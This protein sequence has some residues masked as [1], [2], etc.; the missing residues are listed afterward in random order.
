[1]ENS[2]AIYDE[3][4]DKKYPGVKKAK[5]RKGRVIILNNR[6]IEILDISADT[7]ENGGATYEVRDTKPV[8]DRDGNKDDKIEEYVTP[9][10]DIDAWAGP[11]YGGSRR[12]K[13]RKS[14]R[15]TN[16]KRK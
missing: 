14:R 5:F 4:M 9:A 2:N 15:K 6:K 16:R 12:K 10:K 8:Y 1:M 3:L 7:A 13:R 11:R